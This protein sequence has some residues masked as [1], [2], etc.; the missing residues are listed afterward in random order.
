ML[1]LQF[2]SVSEKGRAEERRFAALPDEMHLR[3]RLAGDI[4]PHKQ[5]QR[6]HA[7][8]SSL[9]S[10]K[11]TALGQVE[12]VAAIKVA[13][14][15][16]GLGDYG[17][18]GRQGFMRHKKTRI[19]DSGQSGNN[20]R[21]INRRLTIGLATGERNDCGFRIGCQALNH[22]SSILQSSM[23]FAVTSFLRSGLSGAGRA[24]G[25][26]RVQRA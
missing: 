12:T 18:S 14:R 15:P 24:T 23:L 21:T 25:L 10:W 11:E 3:P 7:H 19:Q 5:F 26:G 1:Y 17:K 8:S 20:K 6:F 22:Q 4:L 2:K 16:G 9:F 13:E